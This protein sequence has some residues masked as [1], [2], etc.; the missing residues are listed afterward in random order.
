VTPPA[1]VDDAIREKC[2]YFKEK[3]HWAHDCRKKK[4]DEAQR[5]M[6]NLSIEEDTDPTMMTTFIIEVTEPGVELHTMAAETGEFPAGGD[7]PIRSGSHFLYKEDMPTSSPCT[8]AL[9]RIWR[10]T[11]T[12][13]PRTTWHATSAPSLSWTRRSPTR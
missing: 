7:T 2:R 6:A 3:G 13:A 1:A 9:P 4:C 8:P 10:G 5:D 12:P 11:W